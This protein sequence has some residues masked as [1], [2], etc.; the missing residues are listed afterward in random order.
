MSEE[1]PRS[2]R[3]VCQTRDQRFK[4]NVA[5]VRTKKFKKFRPVEETRIVVI[6]LYFE[7]QTGLSVV[8]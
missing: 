8:E 3:G 7:I 2:I 6:H 5:A 4:E 1:K